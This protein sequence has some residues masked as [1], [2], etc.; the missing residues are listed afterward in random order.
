MDFVLILA[1]LVFL[2]FGGEGILKGSVSLARQYGLSDFLVGAVIVGFGTSLPELSVSIKAALN[3]SSGL[4]LGNIV[5]SN[6]ANILLIAGTCAVV[7]P[8][9]IKG[10]APLRDALI[11]IAASVALCGLSFLGMLTFWAG[12]FLFITLCAY[13][14]YSYYE[15]QN[16]LRREKGDV[17]QRVQEDTE[18]EPLLSKPKAFLFCLAGLGLL[19]GGS[20]MLVDGAKSVARSMGIG[21][22]IIGL[23]LIAIGT[24]LPELATGLVAA[25]RKHTDV[26]IGN[27][28][29]SS[30][31]NILAILGITSMITPIPISEHIAQFDVWIMLATTILFI[32]FLRTGKKLDRREG[33]LML[34]L[35]AVY[36]GWLYLETGN[37]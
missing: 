18:G 10:F 31:F 33:F 23:T 8:I 9:L 30:I 36:V 29:G 3:D 26:L 28:L 21:E 17:I 15:D 32:I 5:G 7:C 13:L 11:V 2:F 34:F 35:Y 37:T 4:V 19:V 14:I 20:F 6:I 25:L 22:D 24:S 27:I 16:R 1:G 12:L